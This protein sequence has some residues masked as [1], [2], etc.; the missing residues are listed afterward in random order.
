MTN[1]TAGDRA[2]SLLREADA[3]DS[4]PRRPSPVF[5]PDV[6]TGRDAATARS[7]AAMLTGQAVKTSAR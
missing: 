5:L 4:T 3:I 2:A 6:K 1:Y 7:I